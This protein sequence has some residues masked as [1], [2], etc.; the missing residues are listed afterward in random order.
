MSPS[1]LKINQTEN[2]W[3][4]PV[5]GQQ[6]T[7]CCV[8]YAAVE[9]LLANGIRIYIESTFTYVS[10]DGIEYVLDPEAEAQ[11]LAPIIQLRRLNATG[12]AAFKDGHLEVYF[13]DGSR[14]HVPADQEFEAWNI[15]GPGGLDGLKVMSTPGGELAIW[16]DR[17]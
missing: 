12:G 16:Q 15:S 10:P 3:N 8:D 6:V 1:R 5:A 4:L 9:L 7:R 13:E 2:S 17:R 11:R 14:I